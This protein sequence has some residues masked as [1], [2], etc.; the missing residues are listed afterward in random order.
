[1]DADHVQTLKA[2]TFVEEIWKRFGGMIYNPL[3]EAS[4]KEQE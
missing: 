4:W 3:P 2:Q 1:L